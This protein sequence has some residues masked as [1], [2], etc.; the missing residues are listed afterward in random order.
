MGQARW[1][2]RDGQ[3]E[4][5][6]S[7]GSNGW[8]S[9]SMAPSARP[10]SLP[11]TTL[12]CSPSAS[13]RLTPR[14]RSPHARLHLALWVGFLCGPR[15]HARQELARRARLPRVRAELHQDPRYLLELHRRRPPAPPAPVLL[16]LPLLADAEAAGAWLRSSRPAGTNWVRSGD[17]E[18]QQRG[19]A[20]E[21][22]RGRAEGTRKATRAV[23]AGGGWAAAVGRAH[24]LYAVFRLLQ[25]VPAA[26]AVSGARWAACLK[27]ARS[28]ALWR[29]Q[30]ERGRC[31][32]ALAML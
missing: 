2:G 17:H 21:H 11:A 25:G 16:L 10:V 32:S 6:K 31:C 18:A 22:A 8:L 14:C 4:Q 3:L 30:P 20:E 13:P 15:G 12:C 19:R 5:S 26:G 29:S 1:Q 24:P 23:G 27:L 9:P 28:G 7:G